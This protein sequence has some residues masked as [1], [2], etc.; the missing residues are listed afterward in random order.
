VHEPAGPVF[1]LAVAAEWERALETG[2]YR[3]STIDTSLEEEG[4]IHASFAHQAQGVADRHYR[5]RDDIVLLTVDTGR[6]RDT[7][8]DLRVEDASGHG[9]GFPH[10]YGPLPVDAVVDVTPVPVTDDG[11]LDLTGRLDR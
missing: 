2:E 9:E 5:G 11:R 6:L 8:V 4:Y 7:G 10:L 3:R 1:H